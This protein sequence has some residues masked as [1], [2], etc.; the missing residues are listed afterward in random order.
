MIEKGRSF[1]GEEHRGQYEQ[2]SDKGFVG[3]G[4]SINGQQVTMIPRLQQQVSFTTGVSSVPLSDNYRPIG[5][6][7]SIGGRI[8]DTTVGRTLDTSVGKPSGGESSDLLKKIEEQLNKSK[9]MYPTSS[10]IVR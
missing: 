6:D 7:M 1:G 5:G 3:V 9:Q 4:N 2:V 10:K 8:L